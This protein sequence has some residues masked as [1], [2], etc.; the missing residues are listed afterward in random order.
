MTGEAVAKAKTVAAAKVI[1]AVVFMRRVVVR[2]GWESD[3][4]K[5]EKI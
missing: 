4:K 2:R 3:L 1:K 5:L